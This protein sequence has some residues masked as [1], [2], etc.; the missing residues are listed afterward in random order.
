MDNLLHR[1]AFYLHY[2][3]TFQCQVDEVISA[4]KQVSSVPN[5]ETASNLY[6][7]TF[8]DGNS[9][10]VEFSIRQHS[11]NPEA[12]LSGCILFDDEIQ[13]TTVEFRVFP[14]RSILMLL[15]VAELFLFLGPVR[16]V[17]DDI[18][19]QLLCLFWSLAWIWL[20]VVLFKD[21]NSLYALVINLL[22]QHL[23]TKNK[24]C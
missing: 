6:E 2:K 19:I 23:I 8:S 20:A 4:L 1:F 21:R 10:P 7:V 22:E 17:P 12:Y 13:T 3:T 15:A 9:F 14:S 11:R 16:S 5:I 18:I 24:I